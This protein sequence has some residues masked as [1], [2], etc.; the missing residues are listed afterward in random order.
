MILGLN[1]G[2]EKIEVRKLIEARLGLPTFVEND[3]SAAASEK[4]GLALRSS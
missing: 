4:S 3:A 1:Q 2:W